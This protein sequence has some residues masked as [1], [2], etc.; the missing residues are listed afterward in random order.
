[1]RET[2]SS[3]SVEGVVGNHDPY[4]DSAPLL[5]GHPRAGGVVLLSA[6]FAGGAEK[7]SLVSADLFGGDR[8]PEGRR[9]RK[10]SLRPQGAQAFARLPCPRE[11]GAS[12]K[13][14]D[15]RNQVREYGK[16]EAV[17]PRPRGQETLV[18]GAVVNACSYYR[19]RPTASG[20][21]A[22]VGVSLCIRGL[23][24]GCRCTPRSAGIVA[25]A[26]A[27]DRVADT[28]PSDSGVYYFSM[29]KAQGSEKCG[30]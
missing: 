11:E 4:S 3:G 23:P 7:I 1:M 6:V 5:A 17:P 30:A 28:V 18:F 10:P 26:P 20:A 8:N 21:D 29:K 2:R 24:G 14:G 22:S 16:E 25:P 15:R 27:S 9:S 12:E 19:R 13:G